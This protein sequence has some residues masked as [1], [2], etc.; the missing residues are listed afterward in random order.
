[1]KEIVLATDLGG[2]NL[3]MAAVSR[4]GQVLSRVKYKTPR[5]ENPAEIVAVI[6]DAVEECK[7]TLIDCEVL[8][9]GAAVPGVMNF[10]K[11]LVMKSPNLPELD[12]FEIVAAL[13]KKL[14]IR[15][16]LENDAN[17]AAIGENWLGASK[18]FDTS[19][20]VTLG[21]GVGGGV[22]INGGILRGIDGTAGEIGHINVEP[23]GQP[24]GCGSHGCVEQYASATAIVRIA[25]E[26]AKENNSNTLLKYHDLTSENVFET[27]MKGDESAL[28][29]FRQQ[30]YYLGIM[31]AG[32]INTLNPEAIVIGGGAA[33]SWDLFISYLKRQIEIR[34]YK[35]PAN[36]AK[37]VPA[38]LGDDAGILG[39]A[40]LAFQ[41]QKSKKQ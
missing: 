33:G 6:T 34:C 20:M 26:V 11:G 17:A 39:V 23:E 25:K 28:E 18:G 1:M 36:R 29:V 19:I 12:G 7:S 27:A 31:L 16:I 8:A 35:Q 38:E 41:M 15:T 30:G 40:G 22:I 9:I 32:L 4:D 21:T 2:T 13:E 37:I 5:S 3:R 10:E 24:C 14:S